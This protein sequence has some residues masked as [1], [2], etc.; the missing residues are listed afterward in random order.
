MKRRTLTLA[1]LAAPIGLSACMT[2]PA[3]YAGPEIT[4]VVVLKGKRRMHLLNGNKAVRSYDFQLG[5]EPEGHKLREGDGRTPEG[6]YYIDRKNPN[7]Q[8]HLSLGISYPNR[9]DVARAKAAGV[10]PGGDIFIHGTPGYAHHKQD[11]TAGCVA[12]ENREM[13]EVFRMVRVGTPV[14]IYP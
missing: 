4:R 6:A 9:H 10:S 14:L 5:F 1:L 13:D 11:W 2:A 8:F 12:V 3:S 7:S